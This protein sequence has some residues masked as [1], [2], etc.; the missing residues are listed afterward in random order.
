VT[1]LD[2][3]TSRYYSAA[4]GRFTSADA[5]VSGANW[6][7]EPQRW[8]RYEYALNN[9]F[10]FVD[11]DGHDAIAAF[12]LGEDYR[13][14]STWEVMFSK[15]TVAE[16]SNAWDSFRDDH[17]KMFHGLSP[18]P[19]TE[20]E[21]GLSVA[22]GSAGRMLH[23]ASKIGLP[24]ARNML[25]NTMARVIGHYPA[26]IK[27]GEKLNAKYFEIPSYIWRAMPEA[28]QELANQKFLDR[29]IAAKAI[30]ILATAKDEIRP[31]SALA[32]EVKYLLKH[33][34]K[35]SLDKTMLIWGK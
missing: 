5:L 28:V 30:V 24:K 23:E 1:G 17:T 4:Q 21:L 16:L 25:P 19:M 20:G 15:E 3:F 35:W 18:A 31:N 8:N 13:D 32:W 9:P 27:L 29:T 12:F 34:Y 7:A 10:K 11:R 2:W 33:G 22:L 6:I 14:V 26:Y